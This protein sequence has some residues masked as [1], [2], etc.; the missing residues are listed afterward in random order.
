MV[1]HHEQRVKPDRSETPISSLLCFASPFLE[2]PLAV[3]DGLR[4]ASG[5]GEDFVLARDFDSPSESLDRLLMSL[6]RS[7][8]THWECGH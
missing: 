2:T 5:F 3:Q 1:Q 6:G 8:D 4:L 7:A